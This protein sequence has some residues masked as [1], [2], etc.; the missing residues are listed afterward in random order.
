MTDSDQ[1]QKLLAIVETWHL[2]VTP[3]FR[4]FRC[5]RCQECFAGEAW[6]YFLH[7]G[8]YMTPVHFCG[9]CKADFKDSATAG[10][11]ARISV[12]RETFKPKLSVATET[13]LDTISDAWNV[14]AE[15]ILK[16]FTCDACGKPLPDVKAYH[17]WRNKN[18]TLIEYHFDKSCGN[19]ILESEF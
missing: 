1:Q 9:A 13:A 2:S 11:D 12:G 18:G 14:D 7:E 4:G 3:E 15:P 10:K 17:V 19:K 8:G 5:A 6:H 16:D